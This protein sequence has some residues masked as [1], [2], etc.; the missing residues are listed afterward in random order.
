MGNAKKLSRGLMKLFI[1]C[2]CA[3]VVTAH[4]Q[5]LDLG[6]LEWKRISEESRFHVRPSK[7]SPGSIELSAGAI[8]GDAIFQFGGQDG[9]GY[10]DWMYALGIDSKGDLGW[11]RL[12][13]NSSLNSV[14]R[15]GSLSEMSSSLYPSP[16]S[17]ACMSFITSSH[18]LIFGGRGLDA[19]G[20]EGFL[21]DLWISEDM[22]QFGWFAGTRTANSPTVLKGKKATPSGRWKHTCGAHFE[23]KRMVM[24]GGMGQHP[25]NEKDTALLDDL[26]LYGED[27]WE[28]VSGGSHSQ[29]PDFANKDASLRNPG[30]RAEHSSVMVENV[31]YT[32]GGQSVSVD[33][34]GTLTEVMMGDLW[35]FDLNGRQWSYVQG[36]HLA[37]TYAA[38]PDAIGK[39]GAGVG[40]GARVSAAMSFNQLTNEIYIFGGFGY[41]YVPGELGYL[42]DLWSFNTV[43]GNFYWLGGSS[44]LNYNGL[45]T[46]PSARS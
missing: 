24:F 44:G 31:F 46:F 17:G 6:P 35:K 39:G 25:K 27:G 42:N 34:T 19:S 12:H 22:T 38:L 5:S 18:A 41:G 43:D 14:G 23:T 45:D 40:P 15:Y 11:Q 4:G 32:F 36:S 21:N 30:S 8:S 3:L 9:K 29:P 33:S 26:F 28:Y 20:E 1:L 7:S 10:H 2:V 37:N 13:G 16:R